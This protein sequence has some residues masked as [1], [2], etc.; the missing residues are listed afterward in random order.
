[1]L[2]KPG[3]GRCQ[4]EWNGVEWP[5]FCWPRQSYFDYALHLEESGKASAAPMDDEM[6]LCLASIESLLRE[7]Y[8]WSWDDSHEFLVETSSFTPLLLFHP[9]P[10]RQDSAEGQF[11][12]VDERCLVSHVLKCLACRRRTQ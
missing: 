10:V 7:K 5:Q 1:M 11:V 6:A 12:S 9:G 4:I 3:S 8:D 2:R